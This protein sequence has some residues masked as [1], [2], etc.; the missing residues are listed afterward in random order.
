MDFTSVATAVA[1]VAA[2]ISLWFGYFKWSSDRL[3]EQ[4]RTLRPE[5]VEVLQGLNRATFLLQADAF[6]SVES[7]AID[8]IGKR[9]SPSAT[10]EEIRNIVQDKEETAKLSRAALA[11]IHRSENLKECSA[12]I[13]RNRRL[14]AKHRHTLPVLCDIVEDFCLFIEY[15]LVKSKDM[16]DLIETIKMP[17]NEKTSAKFNERLQ[18]ASDRE[19]A[20]T[21]IATL[22]ID[23]AA[24]KTQSNLTVIAQ[25]TKLIEAMVTDVLWRDDRDLRKA[26]N[27]LVRISQEGF[28]EDEKSHLVDVLARTELLRPLFSNDLWIE[29]VKQHTTAAQMI[30]SQKP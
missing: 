9:I 8:E 13:A 4:Y 27:L 19:T 24:Q 1:A 29:I 7:A 15:V 12:I 3:S 16:G 23:F 2:S 10:P 18:A 30:R 28:R 22:Y 25:F 20:I 26:S 11:A 14:A 6:F 5:M 17:E 21:I